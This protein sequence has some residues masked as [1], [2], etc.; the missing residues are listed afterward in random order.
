M[1]LNMKFMKMFLLVNVLTV[2]TAC[3][4]PKANVQVT[5]LDDAGAKVENAD[6]EIWLEE[7]NK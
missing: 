4:V 5:V 7:L 3:A 6:V 1:E 2:L